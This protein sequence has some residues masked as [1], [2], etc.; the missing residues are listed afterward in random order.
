MSHTFIHNEWLGIKQRCNNP[1]SN[2][3]N[4]YGRR[5]IKMCEK[6]END[7]IAFYD[8]VSKLPNYGKKGYTLDRIDNNKGYE[9]NNVRWA[10]AKEQCRNRRSN[11]IVEYK[12]EKMTLTEAAEKSGISYSC[13]NARIRRN[14]PTEHLFD[15]NQVNTEVSNQIAKG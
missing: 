2:S 5:G 12:G 7:F 11:V 3:Y 15:V 10:T 6:W 14:V 8:Y 4:R 1:K 9:P 13:L